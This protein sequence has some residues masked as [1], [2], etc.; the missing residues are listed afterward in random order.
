M[1]GGK[2]RAPVLS[3]DLQLAQ[4]SAGSASHLHRRGRLV[5]QTCEELYFQVW[6]KGWAGRAETW[7]CQGSHHVR[8]DK[9][10]DLNPYPK[11]VLLI[12]SESA[13]NNR[14]LAEKQSEYRPQPQKGRD[15]ALTSWHGPRGC[16]CSALSQ[17]AG[18]APSRMTA[19]S[20]HPFGSRPAG[21]C[22]LTPVS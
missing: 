17:G 13:A 8:H 5:A 7:H 6:H 18:W 9:A 15:R 19:V 4:G 10:M 21:L 1:C 3:Q 12:C 20:F 11:L 2:H 14:R 22:L 16:R